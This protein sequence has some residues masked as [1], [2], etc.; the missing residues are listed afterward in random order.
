[1]VTLS[2]TGETSCQAPV[3]SSHAPRVRIAATRGTNA[4]GSITLRRVASIIG[5][6]KGCKLLLK[7]GDVSSTHCAVINTGGEVFIR[8]LVSRNGTF[9]NDLRAEHERIQDGDVIKIKPWQLRV[10]LIEPET[11][12]SSDVTGLGLEPAPAVVALQE[13]KSGNVRQLL[14]EVNLLGRRHGCDFVIEDRSV[15][16]A[17]AMV[18]TYLSRVVVFDLMSRNGTLVNGEAVTF[19]QVQT[20]DLLTIGTV[21]LRVKIVEPSPRV[22]PSDN[23]QPVAPP[24]PEGSVTDH[25]DIRA[26][27]LDR[28]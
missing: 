2:S 4:G 3:V 28:R 22:E 26:A 27:E 9:L 11:N 8:D 10:A 17:H 13:I 12:D 21:D 19:S 5:S 16:R 14:R 7:H 23:G 24:T 20:D 25:I 18:F 6:K 1:M 15:S